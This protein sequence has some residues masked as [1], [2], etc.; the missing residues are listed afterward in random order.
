MQIQ[1]RR[2]RKT[3]QTKEKIMSAADEL[4]NFEGYEAITFR[5]LAAKSGISFGSIQH[6]YGTKDNLMY[7]YGC[8]LFKQYMS[9]EFVLS[10][11]DVQAS[12]QMRLI[13]RMNDYFGAY[14]AFAQRMGKAFMLD[15]S[16]NGHDI[17]QTVCFDEYIR[18]MMDEAFSSHTFSTPIERRE[19]MEEDILIICRSIV[20]L[21]CSSGENWDF[22]G[23]LHDVLTRV[24]RRFLHDK[25]AV[26]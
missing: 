1:S 16:R 25:N 13:N 18:P 8:R 6:H 21:W 12:A 20:L 24:L 5:S 23:D 9:E 3:F 17:F 11:D 15:A 26:E 4:F 7:V 22:S 19:M 14:A 2:E 10:A